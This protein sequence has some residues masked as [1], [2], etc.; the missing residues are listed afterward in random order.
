MRASCLVVR[1]THVLVARALSCFP[2]TL[3]QQ[4]T[5]FS[6]TQPLW[7]APQ[8]PLRG[9]SQQ[10]SP[11]QGGGV[12]AAVLVLGKLWVGS[13]SDPHA[14]GCHRKDRPPLLL[15]QG[16]T[17]LHQCDRRGGNGLQE[18]VRLGEKCGCQFA[19]GVSQKRSRC[20]KGN[21]N[22]RQ[23][24]NH[25][26]QGRGAAAAAASAAAAAPTAGSHAAG[27]TAA[28]PAAAAGA[29]GP[30]TAATTTTTGTATGTRYAC[31]CACFRHCCARFICC[32][33]QR[34]R[35]WCGTPPILGVVNMVGRIWRRW[36]GGGA[37]R[38]AACSPRVLLCRL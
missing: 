35:A 4:L 12:R 30:A 13:R 36:D 29:D 22:R 15:Q 38:C 11:M 7:P 32:G 14:S 3:S 16:P 20:R 33:M 21:C 6:P 23:S 19:A 8:S 1:T 9:A 26:G 34:S 27:N 17:E 24:P 28:A 5:Q 2:Q 18:R 31:H 10:L 25:G 37:G